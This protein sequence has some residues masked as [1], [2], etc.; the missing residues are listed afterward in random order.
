MSPKK[1]PAVII[2]AVVILTGILLRI[3]ATLQYDPYYT[4]LTHN[5]SS[6]YWGDSYW[7]ARYGEFRIGYPVLE[8]PSAMRVAFH[9]PLY[10]IYIGLWQMSFGIYPGLQLAQLSL[11]VLGGLTIF[12]VY[13]L[14]MMIFEHRP[15]ALLAATMIAFNMPLIFRTPLILNHVLNFILTSCSLFLL[16][17]LLKSSNTRWPSSLL[18]GVLVSL[19]FLTRG[20]AI[21][22]VPISLLAF[23]YKLNI[24]DVFSR[25][26]GVNDFFSRNRGTLTNVALILVPIVLIVGYW[27][28]RNY[29]LLGILVAYTEAPLNFWMG[30]YYEATGLA[31]IPR[32]VPPP[33]SEIEYQLL[34]S[35]AFSWIRE[36]PWD[37]VTLTLYKFSLIFSHH[38]CWEWFVVEG[39]FVVGLAVVWFDKR[40]RWK[41]LPFYLLVAWYYFLLSTHTV[42]PVTS[43][44]LW[45]PYAIVGSFGVCRVLE[46]AQERWVKYDYIISKLLP[47]LPLIYIAFFVAE[48]LISPFRP[49]GWGE[50]I[51]LWPKR[52]LLKNDYHLTPSIMNSFYKNLYKDYWRWIR[53]VTPPNS[54]IITDKYPWYTRKYT[55]RKLLYS[56]LSTPEHHAWMISK[57]KHHGSKYPL[58]DFK[59]VH[60]DIEQPPFS[61]ADTSPLYSTYDVS[62]TFIGKY[63]IPEKIEG[64]S[65]T[66]SHMQYILYKLNK[67]NFFGRSDIKEDWDS[68]V[69]SK[70]GKVKWLPDHG[71]ILQI[72]DDLS[73]NVVWRIDL[74]FPLVD[75]AVHVDAV[76]SSSGT[77]M[78]AVSKDGVA[79]KS[80]THPGGA[81]FQTVSIRLDSFKEAKTIYVKLY[82]DRF[83]NI[84]LKNINVAAL[85]DSPEKGYWISEDLLTRKGQKKTARSYVA[86]Q[87]LYD[88]HCT[89][90]EGIFCIAQNF[91]ARCERADTIRFFV[92][93]TQTSGSINVK[94][95]KGDIKYPDLTVQPLFCTDVKLGKGFSGWMDLPVRHLT[96]KKGDNYWLVIKLVDTKGAADN[97]FTVS[98]G[99]AISYDTL[100]D[101]RI[102]I[103]HG[104]ES[105]WDSGHGYH[106]LT[107]SIYSE[108]TYD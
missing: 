28:L 24:V 6:I 85:L 74:P 15:A 82:E 97:K 19:S 49:P 52:D 22:F 75:G 103:R 66:F 87:E 44:P 26:T 14:S 80:A 53:D 61:L 41:I 13:R 71:G 101:G 1:N 92:R 63:L 16:F 78:I 57:K 4:L 72:L 88:Y 20:D 50:P 17:S 43:M 100:R 38:E 7:L 33:Q 95:L 39:M 83:S 31:G 99:K 21:G 81:H 11:A 65:T 8:E 68:I 69:V 10:P 86:N 40:Y 12:L 94:L 35:Y 84:L 18:T 73:A 64:P 48:G 104:E 67:T 107:F 76:S 106:D 9:P 77:R 36:N 60:P 91:S 37:F 79:W 89:L 29:R 32:T 56:R 27:M 90:G 55:H 58:N 25:K 30:N 45:I 105:S 42:N 34:Y 23:S 59:Y 70:Q 93:N 98:F 108:I 2:L 51:Y 47:V 62:S 46:T 3:S 96:F 102:L 5:D 54:V